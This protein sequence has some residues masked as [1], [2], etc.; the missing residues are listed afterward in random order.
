M[1]DPF[2]SRVRAAAVAGWW[3]VL[4]AVG[5][6]TILWIVSLLIMS[7]RPAWFVEMCGPYISWSEVAHLFFWVITAFK[8]VVWLLALLVVWL[9]LWGRQLKKRA[10]AE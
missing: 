10:G 2:T 4:V 5:F 1:N 3:T 9:T 8:F 7:N 6:A